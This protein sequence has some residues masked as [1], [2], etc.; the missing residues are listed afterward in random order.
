MSAPHSPNNPTTEEE[1]PRTIVYDPN[2]PFWEDDNDD[3]DS[4]YVPALGGSED[5]DDEGDIS[6]HGTSHKSPW[7]HMSR[8]GGTY[9]DQQ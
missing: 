5:E 9:A 1:D 7:L 6:F 4:E 3:M 2:D 8:C